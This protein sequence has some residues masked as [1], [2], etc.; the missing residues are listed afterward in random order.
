MLRVRIVDFLVTAGFYNIDNDF[1]M[2]F[3][4]LGFLLEDNSMKFLKFFFCFKSLTIRGEI[5]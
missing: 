3:F 4:P 5:V 1:E 2:L